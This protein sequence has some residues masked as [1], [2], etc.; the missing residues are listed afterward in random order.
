VATFIGSPAMNLVP[1]PAVGIGPGTMIAG[2]RPEHVRL[3]APEPGSFGFQAVVE[4]VEYLGD[5]LLVHLRF[6]DGSLVA[7]L[8]VG[9]HVETQSVLTFAVAHE[10]VVF[11]EA[12]TGQAAALPA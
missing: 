8:A 7:K 11:F 4:V 6:G 2:F 5:E 10:A 1:A 12:D 9:Q 3:G